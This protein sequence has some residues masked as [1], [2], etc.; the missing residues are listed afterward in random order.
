MGKSV[1]FL[2]AELRDDESNLVATATATARVVNLG[3]GK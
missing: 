1:A 2:E 3:G